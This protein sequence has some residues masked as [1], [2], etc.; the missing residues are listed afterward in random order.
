MYSASIKFITFTDFF[1]KKIITDL[2]ELESIQQTQSAI[3]PM[4]S[5]INAHSKHFVNFKFVYYLFIVYHMCVSMRRESEHLQQTVM[6][7]CQLNCK[8]RLAELS[9]RKSSEN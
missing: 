2:F 9:K 5:C 6:V 3:T 8:R 4:N 7:R 1:L